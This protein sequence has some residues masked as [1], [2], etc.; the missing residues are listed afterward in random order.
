MLLYNIGL[1]IIL[2]CAS[3]TTEM[4]AVWTLYS[5]R[6][7]SFDQDNFADLGQVAVI[8]YNP[9]GLKIKEEVGSTL[10]TKLVEKDY[11]MEAGR[12]VDVDSQFRKLIGKQTFTR[13]LQKQIYEKLKRLGTIQLIPDETVINSAHSFIRIQSKK[14]T[15]N[16]AD[17]FKAPEERQELRPDYKI[18]AESLKANTILEI[19]V[20]TAFIKPLQ[21]SVI[22]QNYRFAIDIQA[23]MFRAKDEEI[24]WREKFHWVDRV[25]EMRGSYL[26]ENLILDEGLMLRKIID[27]N[28]KRMAQM[29]YDDLN[30]EDL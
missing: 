23:R 7:I 27:D 18:V 26:Y 30:L 19:R 5:E 8:C 10:G 13:L 11:L 22:D 1:S 9:A 29:I 4:L 14:D 2:L 16:P 25:D 3:C 6:S 21:L 15:L 17:R 12:K 24:F 20:E 28:S